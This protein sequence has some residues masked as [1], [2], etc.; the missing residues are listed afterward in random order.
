[1]DFREKIAEQRKRKRA[2]MGNLSERKGPPPMCS[3]FL[4]RTKYKNLKRFKTRRYIGHLE[5]HFLFNCFLIFS[6]SV[7]KI[8]MLCVNGIILFPLAFSLLYFFI[9]YKQCCLLEFETKFSSCACDIYNALC[10]I[11]NCNWYLKKFCSKFFL[12]ELYENCYI[13]FF[14]HWAELSIASTKRFLIKYTRDNTF[15]MF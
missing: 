1:M 11:L 7:F 3:R 9:S 8:C 2:G 14:K 4:T 12:L 15:L 5:I 13:E 6:L 10:W